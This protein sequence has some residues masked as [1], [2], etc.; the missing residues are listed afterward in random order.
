MVE[1]SL[2]DLVHEKV[3]PKKAKPLTVHDKLRSE[4]KHLYQ[5]QWSDKWLADL[6]KKWKVC[7]DL[8]ILQPGCFTLPHWTDNTLN[9]TELDL[10]KLVATLFKVKRIAKENRVKSDDF[11]SPNLQLLYGTDPIVIINNNGIKYINIESL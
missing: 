1:D 9:I 7:E 2:K 4:L 10:W 8:L 11:R 5:N 3:Y 6:P